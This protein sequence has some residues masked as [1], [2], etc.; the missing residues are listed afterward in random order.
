MKLLGREDPRFSIS[1]REEDDSGPFACDGTDSIH[2][3]SVIASQGRRGDLDS[4][5][6]PHRK[7]KVL[8]N[9]GRLQIDLRVF[10]APAAA[11]RR[12]AYSVFRADAVLRTT[13]RK[14]TTA[15]RVDFGPRFS[16]Q[17]F[18]VK[19]VSANFLG[20]LDDQLPLRLIFGGVEAVDAA[21]ALIT[22]AAGAEAF[23]VTAEAVRGLAAAAFYDGWTK[24]KSG[25]PGFGNGLLA[26]TDC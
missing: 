7:T 21:A 1:L 4:I 18:R 20:F 8:S 23:A 25:W 16:R 26:P 6:R 11:N 17:D 10:A 9:F 3:F 15:L 12:T 19:G 24:S 22:V 2:A 13:S 14:T 5:L